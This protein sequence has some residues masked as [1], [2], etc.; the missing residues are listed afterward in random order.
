MRAACTAA[1]SELSSSSSQEPMSQ[2]P[3]RNAP[4]EEGADSQSVC[5]RQVRNSY[6]FYHTRGRA[7]EHRMRS[8]ARREVECLRRVTGLVAAGQGIVPLRID[9]AALAG[10]EDVSA[11]DRVAPGERPAGVDEHAAHGEVA[12]SPRSEAEASVEVGG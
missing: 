6:P 5:A 3:S 9:L 1:I 8:D 12:G 11:G 4:N 7:N 10:G 2:P